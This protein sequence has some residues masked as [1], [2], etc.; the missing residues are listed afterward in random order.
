MSELVNALAEYKAAVKAIRVL[1]H[2]TVVAE[3]KH[4]KAKIKLQNLLGVK[5]AVDDTAA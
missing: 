1:Q 4:A 5:L 2:K 3:S